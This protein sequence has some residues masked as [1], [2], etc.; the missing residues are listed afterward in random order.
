MD[1]LFDLKNLS[2]EIAYNLRD[3]INK[4]IDYSNFPK[5]NTAVISRK[6]TI[7]DS[8]RTALY[9]LQDSDTEFSKMTR[10]RSQKNKLNDTNSSDKPK[11]KICEKC[12]S[13]FKTTN[14][15][16]KSKKSAGL[17]CKSCLAETGSDT[18]DINKQQ[19]VTETKFC[20]V[21]LKD[22]LKDE[23]V[24]NQNLY[25]VKEDGEGK[26]KYIV[27]DKVLPEENSKTQ[28]EKSPKIVND[29][30]SNAAKQGQKRT[31]RSMRTE[32]TDN[33]EIANKRLRSNVKQKNTDSKST[34]LTETFVKRPNLR[35]QKIDKRNTNQRPDSDSTLTN[36]VN[37]YKRKLTKHKRATDASLSDADVDNNPD[38]K[39]LKSILAGNIVIKNLNP[40]SSVYDRLRKKS[41][42]FV[43]PAPIM[44]DLT[45]RDVT[46]ESSRRKELALKSKPSSIKK[47]SEKS[48]DSESDNKETEDD[49]SETYTCEECGANHETKLTWLSHKLTHYKQPKLELEKVNVDDTTKDTVST[50]EAVEDLCEDQ[51]ETIAI[52]VDDDEEEA[53]TDATNLD[54][55]VTTE[56]IQSSM[57]ESNEIVDVESVSDDHDSDHGQQ[58]ENKVEKSQSQEDAETTVTKSTPEKVKR[59][60]R[61]SGSRKRLYSPRSRRRSRKITNQNIDKKEDKSET[62]NNSST[63]EDMTT[64]PVEDENVRTKENEDISLTPIKNGQ[65]KEN[66]DNLLVQNEKNLDNEQN[67]DEEEN[68]ERTTEERPAVLESE[69][70]ETQ[71]DD[72][73]DG[74]K[75]T[76]ETQDESEIVDKETNDKESDTDEQED[77]AKDKESE[78]NDKES[79]AI[80]NESETIDKESETIDKESE[81]IDKESET[82]DKE[83]ETIDKESET[84]DRESEINDK[85]S[86]T[87]DKESETNDKESETNDKE[88]ETNDKES[89]TNDKESET[90]DKESETN[91]K[92]SETNDKESETN[93]KESETND[94]ESETNDKES[95]TNDKE[96]ETIEEESEA[97]VEESEA[98]VKESE[99][100]DKESSNGV[101]SSKD[102]SDESPAKDV[103][104]SSK[105]VKRKCIEVEDSS[106]EDIRIVNVN[107]SKKTAKEKSSDRT[108]NVDSSSEDEIECTQVENDKPLVTKEVIV[109]SETNSS[110]CNDD[111]EEVEIREQKKSAKDSADAAA[112]VLQEVLDLASAEVEKRNETVDDNTENDSAD[113]ETLENISREIRNSENASP[114]KLN[115]SQTTVTSS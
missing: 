61:K 111:V 113:M 78:T 64:L 108:E 31:L 34:S 52:R 56:K 14:N 67:K 29:I 105:T 4:E 63:E 83:S 7:T 94:K 50:K 92:E 57:K 81:T 24:S 8:A 27:T 44:I 101:K 84:N 76:A 71:K 54:T 48:D 104:G 13:T 49:K 97:I 3:I 10:T 11:L 37:E 89:E 69:Q 82:N 100:T 15:T 114:L 41:I 109:L 93:D 25:K 2:Q 90:N 33:K 18:N 23:T 59:S 115:S 65:A 36:N 58:T 22:V 55:S 96:S 38:R 43:N 53:V 112:E 79:E 68:V 62:E 103:A 110:T 107:S 98:I 35:G 66:E 1:V 74:E 45:N 17:V 12:Q 16:S 85:E 51:S 72:D 99:A 5:I 88:S 75:E 21:F 95:E 40:P 6:T 20:K 70:K 32:N 86:E 77:V 9:T 87:N 106:D 47:T 73:V 28:G 19:S 30:E 60:S 26:K 102:C 80:D 42:R 39:K 46:E 91:D